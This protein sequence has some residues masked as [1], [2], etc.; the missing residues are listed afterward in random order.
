MAN[1]LITRLLLDSKGFDNNLQK[2]TKQIQD[3]QKKVDGIKGG[4]GN[5]AGAITKFIPQ[6]AVLTGGIAAFNKTI[7]SSESL[8][9]AWGSTMEAATASV[10]SFFTSISS[11]NFGNFLSGLRSVI[12]SAK[13]AYNAMDDLGTFINFSDVDFAKLEAQRSR[14]MYQI[15]ERKK[16]GLDTSDLEEQLTANDNQYTELAEKKAKKYGDA[17]QKAL[18]KIMSKRGYGEDYESYE[19]TVMQY[20]SGSESW[21]QLGKDIEEREK[22]LAELR[23]EGYEYAYSRRGFGGDIEKGNIWEQEVETLNLLK[24]IANAEGEVTEANQLYIQQ[25]NAIT[26]GYNKRRESFKYLSDT[27]QKE[28]KKL[29]NLN[30]ELTSDFKANLDN[31]QI[32]IGFDDNIKNALKDLPDDIADLLKTP[33]DKYTASMDY[34]NFQY[35][36]GYIDQV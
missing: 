35:K 17:Y 29:V 6:L 32:S 8:S 15:K 22:R 28:T 5:V 4:I 2:S 33:F 1:D 30:K 25:L 20:A 27:E 12:D 19:Y 26:Q 16:S 23:K 11:G 36:K 34:L 9:D 7:E 18:K 31:Y 14:I 24:A 13:E 10:D 3:F 21:E